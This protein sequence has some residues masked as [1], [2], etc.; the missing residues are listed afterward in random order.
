[1][2]DDSTNGETARDAA[3]R[4]NDRPS[5]L[6]RR[7]DPQ[8]ADGFE[9]DEQ[10][11][12]R[13]VAKVNQRRARLGTAPGVG[14]QLAEGDGCREPPLPAVVID[15]PMRRRRAGDTVHVHADLAVL[16][17]LGGQH[18]CTLRSQVGRCAADGHVE[19]G[20]ALGSIQ[21]PQ[22]RLGLDRLVGRLQQARPELGATQLLAT[23]R[24]EH[25]DRTGGQ[26]QR[27]RQPALHRRAVLDAVDDDRCS[28]SVDRRREG[29]RWQR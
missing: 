15:R 9:I 13:G 24:F 14:R 25:R 20:E 3:A 7:S 8:H 12:A 17:H 6:G 27:R 1:M 26:Q 11:T 21:R 10:L 19:S 5:H 16:G 2:R 18:T 28:D 29:R 22:K 23:T 4:A